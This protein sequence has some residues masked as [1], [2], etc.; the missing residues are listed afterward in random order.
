MLKSLITTKQQAALRALGLPTQRRPTPPG[1]FLRQML[2]EY[3]I[4]I[5]DFAEHIGV[6]RV[7]LSEI[8]HN[9]RNIT[10]DT[11]RRI[12]AGFGMS[13]QFWLNCQHTLNMW[14]AIV[15]DNSGEVSAI[16]PLV[17]V[18]A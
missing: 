5:T 13:P 8:V 9:K 11:A 12:A 1:V 4:S 15:A 2:D 6:S 10:P 18:A 7:R 16:R 14:D 3:Q 17:P